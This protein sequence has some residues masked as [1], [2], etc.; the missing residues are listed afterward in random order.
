MRRIPPPPLEPVPNDLLESTQTDEAVPKMRK[1]R[2]T[3]VPLSPP[4]CG[5]AGRR[6][7]RVTRT[8]AAHLDIR[9]LMASIRTKSID[10]AALR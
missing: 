7:P 10:V 6:L 8:G 3:A 1:V 5:P 2:V 9:L 4:P